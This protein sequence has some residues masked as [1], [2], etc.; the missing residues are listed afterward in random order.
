MNG[1]YSP[2]P[3]NQQGGYP[4]QQGVP[5]QG[6]QPQMSGPAMSCYPVWGN[7]MP[8]PIPTYMLPPT[9]TQ[10]TAQTPPQ[11]T[12]QASQTQ[13]PVLIGRI[14]NDPSDIL[15][16]E[17]PMDGRVAIF[18]T[19]SLQEVY[20]KGWTSNGTM[21]T[22]RYLFDPDWQAPAPVTQNQIQQD[23]IARLENLERTVSSN[24][25]RRPKQKEE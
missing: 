2:M 24:A 8:T 16:N 25:N 23:M 20:I 3:G 19:A 18:P 10:Q 7:T 14:V 4:S 17:V 11:N 21:I 9:P 12:Q 13:V 1:Q 6:P 15:P 5:M 22:R